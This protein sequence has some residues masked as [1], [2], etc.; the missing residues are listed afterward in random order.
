MSLVMAAQLISDGNACPSCTRSE[1]ERRF[2]GHP[3][4][5]LRPLCLIM[6][7]GCLAGW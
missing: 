1:R 7:R 5:K 2:S 6:L 3:S 4:D